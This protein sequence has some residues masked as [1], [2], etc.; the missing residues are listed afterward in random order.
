VSRNH[1]R[2][3]CHGVLNLLNPDKTWSRQLSDPAKCTVRSYIEA[4]ERERRQH[5]VPVFSPPW[6]LVASGKHLLQVEALVHRAQCAHKARVWISSCRSTW[7]AFRRRCT[8]K[9]QGTEEQ[10]FTHWPFLA[11]CVRSFMA[12]LKLR[13]GGNSLFPDCEGFRAASPN[14]HSKCAAM[15]SSKVFL[16]FLH[17]KLNQSFWFSGSKIKKYNNKYKVISHSRPGLK[18]TAMVDGPHPQESQQPHQPLPRKRAVAP[19]FDALP[20]AFVVN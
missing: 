13:M 18:L 4:W 9:A 8:R 19:R 11:N 3:L 14:F 20:G 12:W 1:L 7:W 17:N 5:T 2:H 10:G 16:Q 15:R 6:L